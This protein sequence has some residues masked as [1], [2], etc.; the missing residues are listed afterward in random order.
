MLGYETCNGSCALFAVGCGIQWLLATIQ[1]TRIRK[2]YDIEGSVGS[3]CVKG[4]CL[5][6]CVVAQDEREVMEREKLIRQHAGP[7]VG[8]Y[9]S[10]GGVMTYAPPPR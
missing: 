1:R 3:D 10:P 4:L 8:A 2:M 5:C 6:C 7:A 9:V